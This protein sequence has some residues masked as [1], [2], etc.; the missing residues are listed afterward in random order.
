M[1]HPSNLEMFKKD[2]Q[3]KANKNLNLFDSDLMVALESV[4]T[5]EFSKAATH[6]RNVASYMDN[7]AILRNE[8]D[9]W[10]KTTE[11]IKGNEKKKDAIR[12]H[13]F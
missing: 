2:D 10:D 7:L 6:F 9:Q 8:K 5:A 4:A 1:T 12:R 11:D 13:W 3:D